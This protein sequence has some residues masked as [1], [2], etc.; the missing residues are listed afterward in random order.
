MADPHIET[1][2]RKLQLFSRTME[3]MSILIGEELF[4]NEVILMLTDLRISFGNLL[5]MMGSGN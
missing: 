2:S 4:Y 5:L 1:Y 3:A